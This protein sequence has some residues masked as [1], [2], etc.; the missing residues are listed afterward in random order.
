MKQTLMVAAAAVALVATGVGHGI[1]TDR[2]GKAGVVV[3]AAARMANVPERVGDWQARPFEIDARQLEIGQIVGYVA[4]TYTHQAT[5]NEITMLLVCGRPG[6]VG[7]HTP[8]V[9]YQGAG[10]TFAAEPVTRKVK[11]GSAHTGRSGIS[12]DAE[13]WQAIASKPEP[14]PEH[15][16]IL[17]AWGTDGTW[18]AA[19]NPRL[20]F[21]RAPALYKLY[22]IRR[23]AEARVTDAPDNPVD[24]FLEALL[25]QI[26]LA[27]VPS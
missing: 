24:L 18:Q 16:Q 26:K 7:A 23:L 2:W 12:G 9:C 1:R 22:V 6:S 5:G 14:H 13:F 11:A 27:L 17:W 19:K 20:E 8:D 15:L 10:F 3:A 4:R 21:A 25:P